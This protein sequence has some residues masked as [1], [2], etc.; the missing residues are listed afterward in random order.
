[1]YRRS[2]QSA[3]MHKSMYDSHELPMAH[4][5]PATAQHSTGYDR[6]VAPGYGFDYHGHDGDVRHHK[7]SPDRAPPPPMLQHRP[8]L[9]KI[10]HS[11]SSFGINKRFQEFSQK[12]PKRRKTTSPMS[13]H[14]SPDGSHR[15]PAFK[16]DYPLADVDGGHR[17]HLADE[18]NV[19]PFTHSQLRLPGI[20]DLSANLDGISPRR[21]LKQQPLDSRASPLLVPSS[22]L[23]L[24]PPSRPGSST[25]H[26][27][28]PSPTHSRSIDS[29]RHARGNLAPSNMEATA[30]LGIPHGVVLTQPSENVAAKVSFGAPSVGPRYGCEFCGKT[31]SRPSSLKTHIHTRE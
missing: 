3:A 22:S 16:E 9:A 6:V 30:V 8:V 10:S 7:I 24:P 4:I 1:M 17:H 23:T 28:T 19:S 2:S 20:S 14:H 5:R 11:S 15:G 21:R 31:F 27:S 12:S 26:R 13:V 29:E 18:G 25:R